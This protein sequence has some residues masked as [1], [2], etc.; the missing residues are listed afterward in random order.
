MH[1]AVGICHAF[2]LTACRQVWDGTVCVY[3][4]NNYSD[5]AFVEIISRNSPV[6]VSGTIVT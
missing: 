5:S 2:L 1:T 3:I 6:P 4:Y